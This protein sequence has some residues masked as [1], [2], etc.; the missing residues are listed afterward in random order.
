MTQTQTLENNL[1][2]TAVSPQN[3]RIVLDGIGS[4]AM[5]K[6]ISEPMPAPEAGEVRVRVLASGVAFAD[7]LCWKGMYP[8][9]P[10]LPFTPG[11]DLVGIVDALGEGVTTA[12]VGQSVGAILPHFGANAAYVNVPAQLLVPMPAGLDA[13][14]A[15]SVILNYLTAYRL[16]TVSAQ[17]KKGERVLVHSA[18]GGVG[19]AVLQIGKILGLEMIGTA[20]AGKLETVT[21]Y[22]ATAIDYKNEDFA[23]QIRQEFPEGIDIVL[24]PIGGDTMKKSYKLLRSG[25][26][27]ISF[28]FMG[29]KEGSKMAVVPNLLNIFGYKLRPDG[30][31]A[32]MYGSTPTIAEKE[33]EWYQGALTTLFDWLANGRIQPI[34]GAQLPLAEIAEAHHLLA[35]GS[36]V[37]KVVLI[38]E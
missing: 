6:L 24:D 1:T 2:N 7:L 36:V 13:S 18:A 33:T 12:A 15:V 27:L 14:E 25:G 21:Q 5:L 11:Y 32:T 3:Q 10:K 37:G 23:Q 19:T 31:S 20:S 34:I 26:R 4:P 38:N 16:L 22:G 28:G 9:M 30:K 8:I 29:A 35:T 17:A